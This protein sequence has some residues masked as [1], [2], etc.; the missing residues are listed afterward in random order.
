M[1]KRDDL[2]AIGLKAWH[3]H[4]T[5]SGGKYGSE[6]LIAAFAAMLAAAPAA[7]KGRVRKDGPTLPFAPQAL[8]EALRERVGHIVSCEVV[9]SSS[10]GRLGANLKGIA[11]L[12]AADLERVVSWI[13]AGGTSGWP[14]Q[15]TFQGLANNIDKYI[16]WAR[17]WDKRG[18]QPISKGG[19]VGSTDGVDF[20][21]EVF[22]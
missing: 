17:E 15:L 14:Q 9:A 8:Y 22:K 4:T 10:F 21:F 19:T 2:E 7:G 1:S 3:A 20:S 6:A 18:R 5:A 11:G 13:D 12:E 16:N